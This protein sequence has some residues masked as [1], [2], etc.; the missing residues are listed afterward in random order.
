MRKKSEQRGID[1]NNDWSTPQ[2]LFDLLD[3]EFQF[4]VD[5]CAAEWNYK[6]EK[7]FTADDDSLSF[8]WPYG[9][10]VWCNPP[11]GHTAGKFVEFAY[12]QSLR[13][14]C[15]AVCLV[16]ANTETAWF[17]DFALKGELRFIRGRVHYSDQDGKSGRPRFANVIVIFRP[18]GTGSG[19]V[20]TLNGYK[21]GK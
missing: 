9:S 15:T 21:G 16:P 1:M 5:I 14:R 8:D 4:D 11:Y 2:N 3:S 18:C 19:K 17:Q 10:T 13:Q 6:C 7:Y 12:K 20:S